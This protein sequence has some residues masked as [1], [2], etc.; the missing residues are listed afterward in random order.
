MGRRA[1]PIAVGFA[2]DRLLGDPGRLHPV[3]GFGRVALLAERRLL[4]RCRTPAGQRAAG[5]LFT[6]A[7][8]GGTVAATAVV[9]R[10]ASRSV[11]GS[12]AWGSLVVWSCL[13]GSSLLSVGKRQGELLERDDVAGSRELLPWLCGRDPQ[14]LG[15]EALARAVVESVAENTTDAAIATLFWAAVAGPPGAAAHRAANTLDAMVGHRSDRHQYFGTP[16]ARLDDVMGFIPARIAG[17]L[18]VAW[19]G[20]VAG[21]PSEAVRVW[22]RDARAH[23]SPNGG[24]VEA[25]CAGALGIRLGGRTPYPYGVQ[26]RAVLGDGRE[27]RVGDIDRAVRLHS[28]VQVA[29]AVLAVFA[30]VAA[31][32]ASGRSLL[33]TVASRDG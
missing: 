18:A 17:A 3:A 22:R 20:T 33:G 30:L 27:V 4:N 1:V 24:V 29:A 26:Q 13:G 16:A 19:A 7:L 12:S 15:P 21:S 28:R 23:P 5:L 25:V 2:L 14:A 6:G 31:E 9:G 32:M 8:V 11:L 10:L